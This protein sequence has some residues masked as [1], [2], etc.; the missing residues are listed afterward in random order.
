MR[1]RGGRVGFPRS[2][3]VVGEPIAV[4]RAKPTVA[5]AEELTRELAA[6]VDALH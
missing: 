5:A 4:A 6:R 3:F 1:S 2:G